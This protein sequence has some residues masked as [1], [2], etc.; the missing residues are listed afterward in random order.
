MMTSREA[1]DAFRKVQWTRTSEWV[2]WIGIARAG[3]VDVETVRFYQRHLLLET[4]ARQTTKFLQF[5]R[6][7]KSSLATRRRRAHA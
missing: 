7:R 2:A 4:L 3:G 1:G 6:L 5:R